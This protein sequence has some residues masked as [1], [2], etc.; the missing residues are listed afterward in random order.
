[1]PRIAGPAAL[2]LASLNPEQVSFVRNLPKAELHAHLNGCVPIETLLVLAGNYQHD[3]TSGE[4]DVVRRGLD[5]LNE[6]VKLEK[7][8]DF[9]GLFPAIYQLTSTPAIL[10]LVTADV[11]R[12]FLDEHEV[13]GVIIPP[14]CAYLELR[15]TP[16]ESPHMNRKEYIE[17]VL[18]EVE[19]YPPERAALIICVDRRMSTTDAERCV[20]I[21]IQ[22]KAEGRRVVGIDLCGTP[23]VSC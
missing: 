5:V 15:T 3:V 22:L 23:T 19:R 17:A 9:F 14:E 7:I 6:G 20:D 11:L 2:A 18:V 1:M 12:M 21:A 13:D 4:D 10:Q 8:D 16:R